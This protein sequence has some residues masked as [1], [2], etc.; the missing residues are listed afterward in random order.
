MQAF[1]QEIAV[2]GH[3]VAREIVQCCAHGLKVY[4]R[5]AEKCISHCAREAMGQVLEIDGLQLASRLVLKFLAAELNFAG[6]LLKD[7]IA[8]R[9]NL[10]DDGGQV[11]LTMRDELLHAGN[12]GLQSVRIEL[13][14][15]RADIGAISQKPALRSQRAPGTI[16]QQIAT[17]VGQRDQAFTQLGHAPLIGL[18]E[19]GLS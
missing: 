3:D 13:K 7:H 15:V 18:L 11:L 9:S 12:F 2:G 1:A 19:T 16:W 14:R 17:F 10:P 6:E 4:A 5:I 8:A